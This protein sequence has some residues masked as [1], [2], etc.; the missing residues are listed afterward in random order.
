MLGKR[1]HTGFLNVAYRGLSWDGLAACNADIYFLWIR[2]SYFWEKE[3]DSSTDV[4]RYSKLPSLSLNFVKLTTTTFI[5]PLDAKCDQVFMCFPSLRLLV[6]HLLQRWWKRYGHAT[7]LCACDVWVMFESDVNNLCV[8]SLALHFSRCWPRFALL[9]SSLRN[10]HFPSPWQTPASFPFP[11][12][13]SRVCRDFHF[14]FQAI[15]FQE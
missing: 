8:W 3:L 10:V 13:T 5:H 12:S 1:R 7:K 9:I 2:Q 14:Y 6:A 4:A 11:F 15:H